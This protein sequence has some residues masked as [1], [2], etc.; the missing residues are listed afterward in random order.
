MWFGVVRVE[1]SSV[2][3]IAVAR[4]SWFGLGSAAVTGPPISKIRLFGTSGC[5]MFRFAYFGRVWH[6]IGVVVHD[7][8]V[9]EAKYERVPKRVKE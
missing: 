9:L 4:S 2:V 1:R 8:V 6:G 5:D 7:I 3:A